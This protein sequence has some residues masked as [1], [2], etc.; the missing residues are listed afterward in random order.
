MAWQDLQNELPENLIEYIQLKDD[1]DFAETAKDAIRALMFLY[2]KPLLEKLIPIC[3]NWGYDELVAQEIGHNTFDKVW[4]YPRYDK[5][6]IKST[7]P[8]KGMLLYLL[9]IAKNL[10]ANH[11]KEEESS[12]PFTGDEQIVWDFP[13][14][15]EIDA[16]GERKAILIDRY[17]LIKS[18]LARLSSKHKIIYL[19]YKQY[20]KE[21]NEGFKLPRELL[22]R[23][24]DELELS[25]TSIRIYKN[26]AFEK[27]DEYL[28]IY[29]SK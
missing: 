19:T 22:Q 29:G 4:K 1:A 25:Q 2:Q 7:D 9:G 3:V 12:Y 18:A 14:I 20:E 6:K 27:V 15:G 8:K 17:E 24:R 16:S 13:D 11:K 10:L 5:S 21:I 26:Q 28:K 23:L